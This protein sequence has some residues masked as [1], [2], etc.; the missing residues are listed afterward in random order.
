MS[1][2]TRERS[3]AAGVF[4]QAGARDGP[5]REMAKRAGDQAMTVE[6]RVR[7]AAIFTDLEELKRRR[8]DRSEDGAI[9]PPAGPGRRPFEA[10]SR[11]HC[12]ALP[13][14][15]SPI[16]IHRIQRRGHRQMR[17]SWGVS[18]EP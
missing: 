13:R 11:L 3:R 12:L 2:I 1:I 9:T 6:L 5:A 7:P 4:L 10:D 15:Y 17:L 16:S 18:E 14:F 8:N